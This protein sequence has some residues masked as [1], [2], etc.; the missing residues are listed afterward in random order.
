MPG[1]LQRIKLALAMAMI[2]AF[3]LIFLSGC[4]AV[5]MGKD[6]IQ[7]KITSQDQMD[8]AVSVVDQFFSFIMD[9]DYKKAYGLISR[10]DRDRRSEQYFISEFLDVTD[11]V[12]VEINW[13]EVKN[14]IATVGID[15][16]DSYDG[17]QKMYKDIEVS[18][19]REEDGSWKIVFWD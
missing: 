4:G 5:Q 3:T 17:Q 1:L 18:L 16:I 11:I 8:A 15:L 19:T 12:K 6:F 14:N 13:V 9:K 2:T 10:D 7:G